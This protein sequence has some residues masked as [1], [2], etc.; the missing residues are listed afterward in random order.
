MPEERK[1]HSIVK[2]SILLVSDKEVPGL[3]SYTLP[4]AVN[5]I[6]TGDERIVCRICS[7]TGQK[8]LPNTSSKL[9]SLRMSDKMAFHIYTYTNHSS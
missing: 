7:G 9:I 1:P 5:A 2:N 6:Y 3:G 8:C 4:R